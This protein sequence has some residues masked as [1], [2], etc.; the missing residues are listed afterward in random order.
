M[1]PS[2]GILFLHAVAVP[3]AVA[4]AVTP[5]MVTSALRSVMPSAVRGSASMQYGGGGYDQQQNYGGQQGYDNYGGGQ[6]QGYDAQ[7]GYGA[8]QEYNAQVLWRIY[9]YSGVDGHNHFSGAVS[10]MNQNR[11]NSVCEKYGTMPYGLIANDERILSRWNMMYPVD[12]VSRSQCSVRVLPDGNAVL[13]STGKPPTLWR[14]PGGQWNALYSG[15]SQYLSDGTQ[16]SLDCNNP[17]NAVFTCQNEAAM[18]QGGAQQQAGYEQQGG[19]PPQQ[20]GY[21]QGGYQQDQQQ[22]GYP[23]QG[24]YGY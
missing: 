11:F 9:P 5:H 1:G 20:G 15:Q 17:E 2:R 6:Q 3:G 19:Y 22:G 14:M 7:Q 12:T 4:L 16:I 18:Q 8:P 23:Q 13:M 21:E 10:S 24:G